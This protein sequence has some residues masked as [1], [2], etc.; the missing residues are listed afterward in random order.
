VVIKNELL[1]AFLTFI[2]VCS[3]IFDY[4][5][6]HISD[7]SY[8]QNFS[9]LRDAENNPLKVKHLCLNTGSS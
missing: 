1:T 2:V 3:A 9:R 5:Y 8:S 7:V 6:S 4:S